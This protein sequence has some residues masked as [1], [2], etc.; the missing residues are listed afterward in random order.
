MLLGNLSRS[1]LGDMLTGKGVTM[2][3]RGYNDMDHMKQM[4]ELK[5]IYWQQKGKQENA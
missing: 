5:H 2:A 1:I 3:G 4:E